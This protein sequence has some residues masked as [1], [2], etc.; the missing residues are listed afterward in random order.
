M[1]PETGVDTETDAGAD[2]AGEEPPASLADLPEQEP[3]T[4]DQDTIAPVEDAE[5]DDTPEDDGLAEDPPE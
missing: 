2:E 1:A 3:E 4:S 5:E